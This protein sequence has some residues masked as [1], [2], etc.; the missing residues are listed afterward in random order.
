M[1]A[2]NEIMLVDV[3]DQA[4]QPIGKIPR[5][6]LFHEHANFRVAHDLIFNSQG[7]LLIQQIAS[8]RN[9]HP[10]YWGT[11]VAAYMFAGESYE[12]AANRRLVEELGVRNVKLRYLGKT[13]MVDEGCY[14][15]I[16]IFTGTS[17]GPF[18]F[19]RTHIERLEFVPLPRIHELIETESRRFTPT[20]LEVLRFYESRI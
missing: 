13:S 3:V 19:D 12:D 10:G 17:D 8:T 5:G 20:F 2:P 18:T 7:E 14:K 9:R 1:V 11:S 15:F 6:L 4:D 16:A